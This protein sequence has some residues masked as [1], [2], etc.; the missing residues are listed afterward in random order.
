MQFKAFLEKYSSNIAE[1][2]NIHLL[3]FNSAEDAEISIIFASQCI[4]LIKSQNIHVESLD[5]TVASYSNIVS[6]LETSFLGMGLTYWLRGF[7]EVDKKYRQMMLE[8]LSHYQGPHQII[9]FANQIDIKESSSKKIVINIP[10]SVD[11]ALFAALFVFF[12]KKN[13]PQIHKVIQYLCG[14]YSKISLDQAC[15]IIEYLQVMGKYEDAAQLFERIL[16]SEKSLFILSQHFF[17]KDSAAFF[18]LWSRFESEYPITFWCTYWS[19]QLW[20]AYHVRYFL[21][22]QQSAQAKSIGYRLPFSYLQ[23]DWK[24]TKLSELKNAH[25]FIYEL[26]LAFKNNIETESGIELFYSKFLQNQF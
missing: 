2:G 24:K 14:M 20:R 12:K 15:M 19:E 22:R 18:K 1:L 5:C 3:A 23:K 4:H 21:D 13:T 9:L 6:Q 25:Q 10:E 8:Y 7:H 17:A 26:D 16:E 11:P